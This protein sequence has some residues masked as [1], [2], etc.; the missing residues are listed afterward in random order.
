MY[1]LLITFFVLAIFFSFMCSLWE[2]V[3]LS[4]TP[5]YARIQ[6]QKGTATGN[7]LNAFKQDIDRPLSAIL[8][9]N[10]IAHTVGA[11]GVGEQAAAIWSE[12]NPLITRLV[13]PAAMTLAVLLLSEI[14]PK[15]IGALYWRKLAGFTVASLRFLLVVLAPLVWMSQLLTKLLKTDGHGAVLTRNDFL[16]MTEMGAEDGVLEAV[17]SKMLGSMLRFQGIT[18]SDVMT[19]RTVVSATPEEQSIG[20]YYNARKST[21]FSRIPTF[22]QNNKDHISGYILKMDVMEAMID[23]RENDSVASLKRD[24]IAIGQN[25]AL[26]ELFTTLMQRKEHIA[27]VLDDFGGMAG[28]VTME[29]VI[30]TMLG[31]EI[32]D[33]TDTATD[34]RVLAQGLRKKRAKLLGAI[35]SAVTDDNV[36]P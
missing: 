29:D 22:T 31:M 32:I 3:L 18:A 8:T 30:E 36:T 19:P 6:Q 28:I 4:I 24:I 35:D 26:T 9:L 10:T 15:T 11:I 13:V 20:D 27:V 23:N 34:M 12:S 7:Y 17:E 33:E 25:F 2:A 14:V 1:T 16:A 5:T 21:Q